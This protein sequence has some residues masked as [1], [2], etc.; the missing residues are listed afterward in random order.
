MPR[1]VDP[2]TTYTTSSAAHTPYL[3]SQPPTTEP[4]GATGAGEGIPTSEREA[5]AVMSVL[6]SCS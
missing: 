3:R 6:S 4:D 1:Y 2:Q 5:A